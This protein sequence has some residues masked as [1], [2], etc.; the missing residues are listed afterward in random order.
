MPSSPRNRTLGPLFSPDLVC[1]PLTHSPV[2]RA[3]Q[4]TAPFTLVLSLPKIL[5]FFSL[6]LDAWHYSDVLHCNESI[7]LTLSGHRIVP[8][9]W[10]RQFSNPSG[11]QK[12]SAANQSFS[13]MKCIHLRPLQ[14]SPIWDFSVPS[15]IG[16][17]VKFNREKPCSPS[18]L[19]NI[20]SY[21]HWQLCVTLKKYYPM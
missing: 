16:F 12:P 13:S 6:M 2:C 7:R 19:S 4:D 14:S 1:I 21:T 11:L 18:Y 20:L 8:G 10:V 17:T 3:Y 9:D 5:E 15:C